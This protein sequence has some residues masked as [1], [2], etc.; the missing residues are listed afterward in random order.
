MHPSSLFSFRLPRGVATVIALAVTLA[1]GWQFGAR[2]GNGNSAERG[3]PRKVTPLGELNAEEKNNG[4]SG[5]RVGDF[6][7]F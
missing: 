5:N 3:A 7:A 1:I 2:V 4:S 6:G